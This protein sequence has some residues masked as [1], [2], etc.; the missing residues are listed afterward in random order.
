[1]ITKNIGENKT[2]QKTKYERIKHV[3]KTI[4]L[5]LLDSAVGLTNQQRIH[6]FPRASEKS[7]QTWRNT[8]GAPACA[9]DDEDAAQG[10]GLA[11]AG[12]RTPGW[13]SGRPGCRRTVRGWPPSAAWVCAVCRQWKTTWIS[14]RA[15]QTR[16]SG[17]LLRLW[18]GSFPA[19]TPAAAASALPRNGLRSL[20]RTLR[21]WHRAEHFT[22]ISGRARSK[23]AFLSEPE[24]IGCVPL[25]SSQLEFGY[26]ER[27]PVGSRVLVTIGAH[28]FEAGE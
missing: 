16:S 20:M 15:P 17:S 19:F 11:S 2:K 1:M 3:G 12:I 9:G 7:Y 27:G 4:N 22:D 5:R 8:G 6:Y 13:A 28:A 26:G 23:R 21:K 10:S 18:L 25:P 24:R 14:A